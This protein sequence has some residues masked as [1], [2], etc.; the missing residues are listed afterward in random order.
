MGAKDEQPLADPPEAVAGWVRE[1]VSR[2]EAETPKTISPL[3]VIESVASTYRN[4]DST[5]RVRAF[6]MP[7]ETSAFEAQQ[8]WHRGETETSLHRGN[9]FVVCT[10]ESA[11][12]GELVPFC[13]ALE[14]AWLAAEGR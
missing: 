4:Q 13:A 5:I 1:S 12:Q 6:R 8:K 3:R 2:A 14:A 9:V 11:Q 7:D 10:A